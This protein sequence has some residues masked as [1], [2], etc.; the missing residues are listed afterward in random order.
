MRTV[1][2]LA[3]NHLVWPPG[4]PGNAG[5]HGNHSSR[6]PPATQL[7]PESTGEKAWYLVDTGPLEHFSRGHPGAAL[8]GDVRYLRLADMRLQ[9][10][11]RLSSFQ[12]G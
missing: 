9:R 2:R 5:A 7:S 6:P 10:D 12:A 11:K 1:P 3:R 8:L 4:P